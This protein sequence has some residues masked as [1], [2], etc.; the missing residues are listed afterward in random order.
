M[1]VRRCRIVAAASVAS[2][3]YG[4]RKRNVGRPMTSPSTTATTPPAGSD[5][6]GDMPYFTFR[7]AAV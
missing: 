4:P 3:K 2:A 5:H 1:M 7:N 6:H